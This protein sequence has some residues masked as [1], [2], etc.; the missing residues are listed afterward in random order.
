MSASAAIMGIGESDYSWASGKTEIEMALN[1]V[2]SAIADAGL[3]PG[4][5]DGLGKFSFDGVPQNS[6]ASAL[7]INRLAFC[8]DSAGGAASSV[9]LLA[10]ASAAIQAGQ[11]EAIVCYRS[12]NGRSML[13]LGHL[14]IPER[15]EDGNVLAAGASPFGGEFAGPY[16]MAAPACAFALWADAYMTRHGISEEKMVRALGTVTVRQR[17]YASRNP[18]ALLRDKPLDMESYF[19]SP[20]LAAPLRKVDLCLESDGAC[21]IVITGDKYIKC[22]TNRPAYIL[23]TRQ[24][25]SPNYDHFFFDLETLPPRIGTDLMPG[26][27][28]R[29]GLSHQ[30]VDILGI[31]DAASSSVLYDLEN[32]GFCNPGEAVDYIAHPEVAVNTSG[33]MLA[34]VY[35]QGMNL[36]IEVVRQLR[37][38]S[39]NQAQN[40]K[41]GGLSVGG[42]QAVGLLSN[43]VF[44]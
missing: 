17:E 3:D 2:R 23:D 16:G 13:R 30:D 8:Q 37:G 22:S 26:I 28:S 14:P 43:E 7:G 15:G 40:A 36:I 29:H 25:L 27:L 12:F 19:S 34:E 39:A 11:A 24:A 21:A 4:K 44:S 6:V 20:F 31:Y 32:L 10:A 9:N 5:I 18:L 33:G 42:T 41:F 1:A 38:T 35:L